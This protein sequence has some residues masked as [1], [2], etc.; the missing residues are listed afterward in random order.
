MTNSKLIQLLRTFTKEEFKSFGKFAGS[1]Y[2]YKDKAVTKLFDSLKAFYPNFSN[3]NLTKEFIFN[4]IYPQKAYNDSL[5]K[6]LMSEMF[7]LGKKFLA[8]VNFDKDFFGRDIRLLKELNSRNMPKIFESQLEK[9]EGRVNGYQLRNEEYFHNMYIMKELV[10]NFYSYKDRLSVKR[11][12]NKIIENIIN[13]FLLSLLDIYF[14]MS[15]DIKFFGVN[16]NLNLVSY[17]EDLMGKNKDIIN[18]VV[19]IYYHIFML[20]HR[21]EEAHYLKLLELKKKY[22]HILDNRGKQRIYETLVN[23]CNSC[24]DNYPREGIKYYREAFDIINDEI[25]SGVR[26][27]WEKFSEILFINTV[28]IASKIKEFKWAY[29]FIGKYKD[30]LYNEHRDDIVNFCY[31]VIEYES[32]NYLASLDH[33]A[34]IN[35][36]H[37]VV[38]FRI[39]NHTLL[40]YYEL[41]YFE[42][43]YSLVDTYRHMLAKDKKIE[44]ARKDRYNAFLSLYLKLLDIKSGNKITDTNL[45]KKEIESKSIFAKDWLLEK[46]NEL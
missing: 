23:Y 38:R 39:R 9:L 24:I 15:S 26:F 11:E 14:V 21:Q 8:Y 17:I 36:H 46:V 31:A 4:K 16:F 7:G 34:K 19:L 12:H 1:P 44:T 43:A 33:L 5:M 3:K 18:P 40:N 2:F 32:K 42:Q 37:P 10:D 25:K 30:R 6:Y 13:G 22:L 20:S 41:N 27:N 29:D 28:D 35:L 45:F